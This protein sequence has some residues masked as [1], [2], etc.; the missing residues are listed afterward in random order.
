MQALTSTQLTVLMVFGG[1][2]AAVGLYAIMRPPVSDGETRIKI[3]GLEFNASSGGLLVFV[4]G[5][6]FLA[7]PIFVPLQAPIQGA[8]PV[9]SSGAAPPAGGTLIT[10][11][12]PAGQEVEPND[13]P[14]G[15]NGIEI[16]RIYGG[17]VSGRDKD[18]FRA[19]LKPDATRLRYVWRVMD[20]G[21]SSR[22]N[23]Y[24]LDEFGET[25]VNEYQNPSNGRAIS[26]EKS[27]VDVK[28]IGVS[29][30]TDMP[31]RSCEY[32]F[33]LIYE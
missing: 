25:L 12:V 14:R 30:V 6:V 21:S 26:G 11:V 2:V 8:V 18:F 3:F 4:I 29:L 23:L 5:C 22:C 33:E 10:G 16:G 24:L 28:A 7:S 17:V 32:E 1:L 20:D 19:A 9:G 27:V 15:A 31:D 13:H